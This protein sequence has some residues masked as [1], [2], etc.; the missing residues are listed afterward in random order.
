MEREVILNKKYISNNCF[1]VKKKKK[2]R[3]RERRA[4]W[5]EKGEPIVFQILFY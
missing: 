1:Y 3:E 2:C 5:L 4:T